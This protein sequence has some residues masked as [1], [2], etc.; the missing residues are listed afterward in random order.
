MPEIRKETNLVVPESFAVRRACWWSLLFILVW[1]PT[2]QTSAHA[3]D[4]CAVTLNIHLPNGSPIT[5]TW[6]ELIG[7]DGNG[8]RRELI[9]A[10]A[11]ICDFGFGPHTLRIGTNECLPVAISNLLVVIGSPL[12][13]DVTLNGCGYR[14]S[15]RNA[16]LLYVRAM[17]ADGKPV[18]GA[19]IAPLTAN[20]DSYGRYQGLFKGTR[21]LTVSK[22]GFESAS[23]VAQCRENEE[24]DVGVVMRKPPA[25]P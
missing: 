16:C 10:T 21:E 25:R 13:L 23:T 6:I 15:M 5:S 11:R 20:T 12:R 3:G 7:P 2:M 18:S 19:L 24:L 8:E 14:E 1:L 9:G 4:F 17:D 22:D